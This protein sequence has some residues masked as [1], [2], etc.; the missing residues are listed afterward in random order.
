MSKFSFPILVIIASALL[1][2]S[3]K[4]GDKNETKQ[5]TTLIESGASAEA[6]TPMEDQ[7]MAKSLIEYAG[8]AENEVRARLQTFAPFANISAIVEKSISIKDSF[9]IKNNMKADF[10]AKDSLGFRPYEIKAYAAILQY[11]KLLAAGSS[12]G[13]CPSLLD[14]TRT[15]AE[16]D[17]SFQRL[18]KAKPSKFFS[19]GNFFFVGGAPF[20]MEEQSENSP[21]FKDAVGNPEVRFINN[22]TENGLYILNSLYHFKKNAMD[23]TFG[24]PLQS[25]YEFLRDVNGVGSLKHNFTERIPVYFITESGV[26]PGHIISVTLKL[27]PES[28][29]CRSDQ[30]AIEFACS[31]NI[32]ASDILSVYIPY[33]SAALTSCSI[34]RQG[35]E[36]W[37]ADVDG[38]GEADLAC[39]SSAY[40]GMASGGSL[41]RAIW[42]ININGTWQVIDYG[43]ENDCT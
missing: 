4:R 27:V 15:M 20:M 24:Q 7:P 37:T 23:V 32:S 43:N 22:D 6:Q 16:G 2:E 14:L 1:L 34:T 31:K 42:F 13:K 18:P 30:P 8:T 12:P 40:M 36:L 35:N 17:S 33:T 3:C 10:T 41:A 19:S 38:D 5:D 39:V 28:L 29:G 21:T 26:V 25:Y 11:K 9:T